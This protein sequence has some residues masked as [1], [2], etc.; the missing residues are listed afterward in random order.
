MKV[1]AII[2]A[3]GKG[4]RF[5]KK[6]PKQFCLLSGKPIL[7]WTI[8]RFEK[9]K[10]V[11][12]II[13]VV[14]RGMKDYAK[15]I[16]FSFWEFQ[17]VKKITE[18]GRDRNESVCRGLKE[19]DKNTNLVVIHDGV[20]PLVSSSFIEKLIQETKKYGAVIPALSVKETLKKVKEDWVR[21]TIGKEGIYSV[22]TPQ[23][24]WRDLIS[25]AYQEAKKYKWKS[26]DEATLVEKL[27]YKVKVIPGDERNIKITTPLD[28]KIAELLLKEFPKFSL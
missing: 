8:L 6:E 28:I 20:R 10:E 16:L 17:K 7:Y 21:E 23:V 12:E 18:G 14:P 27:G 11:D 15:K 22:Q 24:F 26:S 13:V 5:G 1:E 19:I 4:E 25:R 2:A 3:G 9:C